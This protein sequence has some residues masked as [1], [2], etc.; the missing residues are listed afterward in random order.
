MPELAEVEIVRRNLERWWIGRA[1]QEVI[2]ADDDLIVPSSRE[3]VIT[4]LSEPAYAAMRRGKHLWVE[5]GPSR[6]ALLFHL[7]MTGKITLEDTPQARF[8]RLAWLIP[9]VG[10]LCFKDSRRLGTLE[11]LAPGL[12][13]SSAPINKLGPEPDALDG[14]SLKLRF[15]RSA[16]RVKE[17]L[18]DQRVIAGVGNIAVSEVFWQLGLHPS[19]RPKQLD[20]D[21]YQRLSDALTSH[22]A[23][24]LVS[25]QA[26]ELH[27]VNQG[28]AQ[29]PFMVYLREGQPCPRCQAPLER[30]T[31]GGRSTYYCPRCQPARAPA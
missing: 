21:D 14:P 20:D 22:F 6:H 16:R 15:G 7:R 17:L 5:L 28:K 30:M 3:A 1:A 12:I 23:Q 25:E 11:H 26:D 13:T 4:A 10:W 19:V 29:N 24:L 27:Y 31:F 18:L 9:E 8:T 2:V